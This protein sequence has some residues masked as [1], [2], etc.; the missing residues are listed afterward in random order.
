M[1]RRRVGLEHGRVIV[2]VL[3]AVEIVAV[4]VVLERR[5]MV[6]MEWVGGLLAQPQVLVGVVHCVE[7]V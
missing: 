1:K 3:R 2:R 6:V 7:R 4:A 5:R